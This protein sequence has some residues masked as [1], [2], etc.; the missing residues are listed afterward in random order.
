MVASIADAKGVIDLLGIASTWA[1][2][3]RA[4]LKVVAYSAQASVARAPLAFVMVGI[5]PV[6]GFHY[7]KSVIIHWSFSPFP[8]VERLPIGGRGL[9]PRG[10]GSVVFLDG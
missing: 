1:R 6:M 3:K 5:P 7:V 8:A 2:R 9:P 4:R 10:S